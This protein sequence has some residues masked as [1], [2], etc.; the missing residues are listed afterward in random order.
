MCGIVGIFDRKGRRTIDRALLLGMNDSV[1]H[2]G[3]DADC[4]HIEPGLGLG[5]RRLAIIDI[6]SGQQPLFSEDGNLVIVFNGE[7]YNFQ[8]L[9]K[10][11]QGCGHRFKTHSDTEVIVYAWA[12]WGESCVNHLNGMFAFAIWDRTAETL[13]LARDRLG[14][15]PLYYAEL[16]DGTI[17]F[18]SELKALLLHPMLSRDV[19][20]SAVEDYFTFGYVPDPK[21]ILR[22]ARKLEPGNTLTLRRGHGVPDQRRY[23]DLSFAPVNA[24]TEAEIRDELIARMRESVK[25]R[26]VAEVPLGAFLSGGVDSSGIVAMM[27]GLSDD[28]VNTCSIS[29]GDP[30][31]NEAQ[32]AS[33]VAARYGTN[34]TVE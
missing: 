17:I 29:F 23:W 24:V 6:A 8:Q 20:P 1:A 31:F 18:G 27:Q 11:L 16:A 33:E 28:P 22:Q 32:Y 25:K 34:H 26:L 12:Q 4:L 7:I 30:K 15:K 21:T 2:R 14:I 10:E 9:R 13:F 5:H 19:D 3:P